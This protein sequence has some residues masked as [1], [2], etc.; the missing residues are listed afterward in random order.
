MRSSHPPPQP[1]APLTT[2]GASKSVNSHIDMDSYI[3]M[4]YGWYLTQIINY[5]V[6]LRARYPSKRLLISKYDYSDAYHHITHSMA[7]AI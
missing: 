1:P 5:I 2:T 6:T 7:A 3:A 4:I